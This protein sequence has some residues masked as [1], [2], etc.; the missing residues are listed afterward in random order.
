MESNGTKGIICT[1]TTGKVENAHL[2]FI[3]SKSMKAVF[4]AKGPNPLHLSGYIQPIMDEP[5][6]DIPG[7]EDDQVNASLEESKTND[8]SDESSPEEAP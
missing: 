7:G 5:M 6:F 4:S 1:L 3:V 2:D 8:A